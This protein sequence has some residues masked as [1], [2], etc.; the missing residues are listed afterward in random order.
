MSR[1]GL[2]G[3]SYQSQS[4]NLDAEVCM[5]FY[6]EQDDGGSGNAPIALYP[7]PGL[8]TFVDLTEAGSGFCRGSIQIVGR[9]FQVCGA[10]FDELFANGTHKNWGTVLNDALPI[11]MAASPQQLLLATAGAA[12]IFDLV[13]NT[14]TQIPPG[15]FDGP[16]AQAA[17]C[18][19]FFLLTIKNTKEF[20]VS[21]PL[22][23]TDW[24]TNGNAI[25]SVFP[26]NIVSM[27]V[28]QRQIWF[29]SDTQSVVY[30]DSGNIF[31]FDVNPNAFIEAGS[32]AENSPAIINNTLVWLGSDARGQG[33]V[34][35]ANGY[36]PTRISNH[37]I[38]FAIQS[39]SKISDVVGFSYQ[40]QG[41]EFYCLYFP[42][43]SVTWV[44]DAMTGMWH[45]RGFWVTNV[46][47]FKAAHYQNHIFAFGMH[48]VGDWQ[49]AK[50]YEMSIPVANGKGGWD[51]VTDAGNPI[52]RVRRAPHISNEQQR[53]F[54]HQLQVYLE[55][56]LGPI[57]SLQTGG[58]TPPNIILADSSARLW[59]VYVDDSG[60][61]HTQSVASGA[62]QT[63]F[64]NDS[65]N[66]TS[67]QLGVTTLGLLT[68]TSVAL[69]A[70]HQMQFQLISQ[71]GATAWELSVDINGDLA[72]A[73]NLQVFARAP[74]A[75]LC[76]SNDGGHTFS[77]PIERDCGQAGEYKARVRWLQL[78]VAR[79]R[80]FE[81][82]VSDPI[83][84]RI[85]DAYVQTEQGTN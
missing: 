25:V 12:Y 17:I 70:W 28:F 18:D 48:L 49:S 61:L 20:Y 62:P 5:N 36:T 2:V 73:L 68:T 24:V 65:T 44:Y 74:K 23:A 66:T 52:R 60:L 50:V 75:M 27:F 6:V 19:D 46:A 42:T 9:A 55:T 59:K 14:L 58:G 79:D 69:K 64:L 37:A 57:P 16:V 51:F 31:P 76:W 26:D 40:D 56:G 32:A 82:S 29:F 39:Y 34:W 3:P 30:Y 78:G 8:K 72:T 54:Y 81:F 80:V 53:I 41:H 43:P 4:L 38:E 13:A 7:T 67:W 85:I 1:F 63:I 21:A 84:W 22:D 15:T 47:Q 10:N 77:N 33:K 11:T 71:S 83:P 35:M 45:Q